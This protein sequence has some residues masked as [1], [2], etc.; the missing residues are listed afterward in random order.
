M[1]FL[2]LVCHHLIEN[3]VLPVP[4]VPVSTLKNYVI[5][6]MSTDFEYFYNIEMKSPVVLNSNYF[7]CIVLCEK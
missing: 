4:W 5:C 1:T 2:S 3:D 7:S 6:I